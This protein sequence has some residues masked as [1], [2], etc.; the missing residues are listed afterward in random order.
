MS[1]RAFLGVVLSSL[2]YLPTSP[3]IQRL[4]LYHSHLSEKY[5]N[6]ALERD[7]RQINNKS[8]A[9]QVLSR[10]GEDLTPDEIV[11]QKGKV[12]GKRGRCQHRDT[13]NGNG[14]GADR[15]MS[16][17]TPSSRRSSCSCSA[18]Q[19]TPFSTGDLAFPPAPGAT[20]GP[21]SVAA[22]W[23]P[24]APGSGSETARWAKPSSRAGVRSF[25]LATPTLQR[26]R[27][28]TGRSHRRDP[29]TGD[30]RLSGSGGSVRALGII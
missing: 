1:T 12:M 3:F 11:P 30:T 7:E 5:L 20:T 16:V 2:T 24:S 26:G 28:S 23:T 29:V 9:S 10:N 8:D 22:A 27:C 18:S 13:G 15:S 14:A 6:S 19:T 17:A 25:P 21:P 4:S